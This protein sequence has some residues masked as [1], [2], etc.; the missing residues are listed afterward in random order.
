MNRI[1]DEIK[2]FML[3]GAFMPFNP[4]SNKPVFLEFN[5]QFVLPVFSTKEKFDEAAKWA[6]FTFATCSVIID[7]EDFKNSVLAYKNKFNFH[8]AA[9]PYITEEGNTRFQLIPFDE[10]EKSYLEKKDGQS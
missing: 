9:D 6:G 4:L 5:G 1:S 2:K 8:V 7:P 3:Q 10:E